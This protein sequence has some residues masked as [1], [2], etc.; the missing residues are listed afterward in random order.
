MNKKKFLN[1]LGYKL[2]EIEYRNKNKDEKEGEIN[3]GIATNSKKDKD[4]LQ[5]MVTIVNNENFFKVVMLGIFEL[6]ENLTEVEKEK[7]LNINGAAILYPYIRSLISN[8][9][10]F[11]SPQAQILPTINF[12]KMY[13]NKKSENNFK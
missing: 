6:S 5:L 11:D 13:N 12:Q 7:F 4:I 8:I 10:A 9:T 1:F 3:I 2:R